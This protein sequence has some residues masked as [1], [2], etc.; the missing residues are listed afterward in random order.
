MLAARLRGSEA[1]G[2]TDRWRCRTTTGWEAAGRTSDEDGLAWWQDPPE[3]EKEDGTG[4][5][6]ATRSLAW[7]QAVTANPMAISARDGKTGRGGNTDRIR[8]EEERAVKEGGKLMLFRFVYTGTDFCFVPNYVSLSTMT[9]AAT[10]WYHRTGDGIKP[11]ITIISHASPNDYVVSID[12]HPTESWIMTVHSGGSIRIWDYNSQGI[13]CQSVLLEL[14]QCPKRPTFCNEP[15][16]YEMVHSTDVE[17]HGRVKTA[18][19][20]ARAGWFVVGDH[21]GYMHVYSY[22]TMQKVKSFKAHYYMVSSLDIHPTEPYVLSAS[23]DYL[24]HNLIKLW[25][26][27]KGWDCIRTFDVR[28]KVRQVKFHPKDSDKFAIVSERDY[29]QVWSIGSHLCKST[30]S[31][32]TYGSTCFD[33]FDQ[34]GRQSYL[35]VDFCHKAGIW[36]C[37][38]AT[39]VGILD[40]HID[41]VTAVCSHPDLPILIT[42]SNDGTVCLWNSLNFWTDGILN[43]GLGPVKAVACLNGSRRIAIGHQLGLAVTEIHHEKSD[44]DVNTSKSGNK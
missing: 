32:E 31:D 13:N 8:I 5:S 10:L 27:E 6:E 1:A 42:G 24:G 38:S 30:L 7:R 16:G 29:A 19:F 37:D 34:G 39:Q 33:F 20:I 17:T 18:K 12:V 43:C 4:V 14:C 44:G 25:D 9:L 41:L 11:N 35:A 28:G 21:D 36:N 3:M 40:G 22:D 15:E 26:W 2:A 23:G